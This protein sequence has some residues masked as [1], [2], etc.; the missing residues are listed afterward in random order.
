M[1]FKTIK[2]NL[3]RSLVD[4]N[5]QT[6]LTTDAAESGWGA[7]LQWKQFELMDAG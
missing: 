5:S 3:P 4:L 2:E 7:T 1:W 6:T